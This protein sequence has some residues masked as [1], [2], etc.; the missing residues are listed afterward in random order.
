MRDDKK[1]RNTS[2][3]FQFYHT[4]GDEVGVLLRRTA[5]SFSGLGDAVGMQRDFP[6][7]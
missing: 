1:L 4:P 5:E 7:R 2:P 6:G 3:A